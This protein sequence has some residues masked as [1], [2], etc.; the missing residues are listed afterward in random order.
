MIIN[1]MLIYIKYRIF[2]LHQGIKIRKLYSDHKEKVYWEHHLFNIIE[3]NIHIYKI[4]IDIIQ[5][6]EG[7]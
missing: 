4:K 7:E 2:Y 3:F 5:L 1:K 6:N